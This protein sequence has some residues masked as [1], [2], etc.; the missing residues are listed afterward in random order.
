MKKLNLN[1]AAAELEVLGQE[2]TRT[3]KGGYWIVNGEEV[4]IDVSNYPTYYFDNSEYYTPYFGGGSGDPIYSGGTLPT[5]TIS[6]ITENSAT[7]ERHGL[8]T[9]TEIKLTQHDGQHFLN[10]MQGT[11]SAA[12]SLMGAIKF[13]YYVSQGIAAGFFVS[14][15]NWGNIET[16]YINSN[17]EGLVIKMIET[18]NPYGYGMPAISYGIYTANGELLG[19]AN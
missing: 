12:G 13:P 4:V 11:Q 8:M 7:S 1:E 5:V 18:L 16:N 17:S 19:L 14:S 2:E 6:A 9:I 15:L 3:I 10:S